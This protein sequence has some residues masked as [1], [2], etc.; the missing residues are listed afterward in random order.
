VHPDTVR[1]WEGKPG[2]DLRGHAPRLILAALGVQDESRFGD[3]ARN[4]RARAGLALSL[5]G[6]KPRHIEAHPLRR[7]HPQGHAMPG[8]GSARKDTV[9]AAWWGQHRAANGRRQ[10]THCRCATK[11]LGGVA[12]SAYITDL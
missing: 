2:V 7:A 1:Y 11:A 8:E 9:Q 6:T 10:G 3:F 5:C 12:R 4:T